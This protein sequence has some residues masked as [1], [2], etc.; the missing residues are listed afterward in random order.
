M[1]KID[2]DIQKLKQ[3]ECEIKAK[4][5]RLFNLKTEAERK[6]L[7]RK[8]MILGR[9]IFNKMNNNSEYSKSI[10]AELAEHLIKKNERNLFD[11]PNHSYEQEQEQEQEQLNINLTA[12]AIE[13]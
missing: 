1:N 2:C 5:D 7:A 8:Q 13:R 9:L 6:T 4:L 11:L 10:L 3:K 12:S